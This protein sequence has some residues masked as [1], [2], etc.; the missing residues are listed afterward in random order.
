MS[1]ASFVLRGWR[2]VTP[3]GIRAAAIHVR[4]GTIAAIT[5]YEDVP[6]AARV[7]DAGAAVVLPGLVDTHVHINDPGR[8]DWEGFTTATIAAAAGG[9]T[10]LV[11]MPLNSIPATTTPA[12]LSVK[13]AAAEGRC[14]VDVAFWGGLVPRD[15]D[16]L[17]ALTENGVLGFKCFLMPSG[18][19]EFEHV[20]EAELTRALPVVAA[21]DVPLLV[22]AEMPDVL[23]RFACPCGDAR[24]YARYLASRPA[25]A[26]TDAVALLVRLARETGAHVHIVHVS[27]AE[28]I[29]LL[30]SARA[31]G[32]RITAET[33]P[34]YLHF[35]A[36]DI[37][38]GATQYKCAPPIRDAANREA[39]WAALGAGDLDL[40]ASD[41][42]PCPPSMKCEDSG[43]FDDAWGGIA[44]LQLGLSVVWTG[45]RARGYDLRD[46]VR[47]MAAGPAALAGISERKG[48]IAAG[49]D[50]DFA[51]FDADAEWVVDPA[52][53]HHRHAVTPYAGARLKGIVTATYLRGEQVYGI[54]GS[55]YATSAKRGRLLTREGAPWTSHN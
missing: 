32:V 10:T 21:L 35:A 8:A 19:P 24:S 49:C 17:R 36:R 40:I 3:E 13:R 16:Q 25:A 50:A 26:E 44:S 11:D 29:P 34:H 9:I 52:S 54:N 37:P 39:L 30:R 55:D 33:C 45:A 43:S 47:W 6:A 1:G 2:V 7:T 22:H 15:I 38:D 42:S 31:A 28:S 48:A 27:A 5:D 12:A 4:D 20:G 18:V 23:E 46:V 41:H 53:L 51:L 14:A